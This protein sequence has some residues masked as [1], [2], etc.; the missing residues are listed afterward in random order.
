KLQGSWIIVS[1]DGKAAP[2]IDRSN[3]LADDLTILDD[4]KM[5]LKGPIL[6]S[7]KVKGDEVICK[8]GSCDGMTVF[9]IVE[10]TKDRLIVD[11]FLDGVYVTLGEGRRIEYERTHL[12]QEFRA[13]FKKKDQTITSPNDVGIQVVHIRQVFRYIN[14]MP[15]ITRSINYMNKC[16]VVNA[17][18]TIYTDA[19][20]NVRKITDVGIGDDDKAAAKWSF[21]YYYENG[22]LIFSYESSSGFDNET[23][24]KYTDDNR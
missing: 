12:V 8:A 18:I 10:I 19:N 9:K 11:Q 13:D 7:Y 17:T 6:I 1:V 22:D 16:G 15:L 3:P 24:E 14:S 5:V 23:E 21:E 4:E 2:K 20:G